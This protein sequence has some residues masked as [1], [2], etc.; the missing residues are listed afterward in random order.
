MK[1]CTY[2]LV[3]AAAGCRPTR[4]A[5]PASAAANAS[6]TSSAKIGV[7]VIALI[8]PGDRLRGTGPTQRRA[9]G[10]ATSASAPPAPSTQ[11]SGARGTP[12]RTRGTNALASRVAGARWLPPPR[13]P[14]PAGV[15]ASPRLLTLPPRGRT[16]RADSLADRERRDF[17]SVPYKSTVTLATSPLGRPFETWYLLHRP[18]RCRP[19]AS[20]NARRITLCEFPDCPRRARPTLELTPNGH[21]GRSQK[22]SSR[23]C[24]R[25]GS[26]AAAS[27]ISTIPA[28]AP[29]SRPV[30]SKRPV[31]STP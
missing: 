31:A 25:N 6:Q 1:L 14:A 12:R 22:R 5:N 7:R 8:V 29:A 9:A 17:V 19:R 30:A 13:R 10:G 15:P 3:A 21:M 18:V 28:S 27:A 20:A 2:V 26:I 16:Q 4:N 24:V 11:P 23:H